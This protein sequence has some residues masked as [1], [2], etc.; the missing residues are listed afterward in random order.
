MATKTQT[1]IRVKNILHEKYKLTRLTI[2]EIRNEYD[3]MT[4]YFD[5]SVGDLLDL[6]LTA[7]YENWQV[8]GE[9]GIPFEKSP[10]A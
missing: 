10:L 6:Y 2:G 1:C 4:E 8:Y 3:H 9:I 5:P 7:P